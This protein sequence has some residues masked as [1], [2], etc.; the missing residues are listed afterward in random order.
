MSADP[1]HNDV[2][3]PTTDP[4]HKPTTAIPGEDPDVP[5][6]KDLAADA[7]PPPTE[8]VVAPPGPPSVRGPVSKSD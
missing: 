2:F 3:D 6:P 8:P 5:R 4:R 7:P 1:I